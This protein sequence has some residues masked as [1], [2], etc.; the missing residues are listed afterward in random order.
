MPKKR[1]L[2]YQA[3]FSIVGEEGQPEPAVGG[4][5]HLLVLDLL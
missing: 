1:K 5:L 2:E 4:G 3:K